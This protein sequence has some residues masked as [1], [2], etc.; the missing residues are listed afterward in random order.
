MRDEIRAGLHN[1]DY[2]GSEERNTVSGKAKILEDA[3]SVIED[4][5]DTSFT[6]VGHQCSVSPSFCRYTHS[7]VGRT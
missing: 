4:S 6:R 2:T 7:T 3:W 5:I 1:S